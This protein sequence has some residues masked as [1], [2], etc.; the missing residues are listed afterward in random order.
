VKIVVFF[1][2]LSGISCRRT[3]DP[4]VRS[5]WPEYTSSLRLSGSS[6]LLVDPLPRLFL[7]G[8]FVEPDLGAGE[9]GPGQ[10][11]HPGFPGLATDDGTMLDLPAVSDVELDLVPQGSEPMPWNPIIS[12]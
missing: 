12:M 6:D 3:L 11:G 1:S 2:V 7:L 4:V 5:S 9:D 8:V 10:P